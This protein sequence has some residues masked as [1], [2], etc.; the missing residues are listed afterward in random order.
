MAE[1]P[2][3]ETEKPITAPLTG[4]RSR[5]RGTR[6]V[7][8]ALAVAAAAGLLTLLAFGVTAQSPN[9]GI[10]D[11]LAAGRPAPAP[12]FS[13]A[14]IQR[15]HLGGALERRLAP[16]FTHQ[17]LGIRQLRGTPVM[18]N[19]WA[20]W[21]DPCRQEAPFLERAWRTEARPAGVLFLGL[22]QQDAT[23]DALAFIHQY[24]IDYTNVHDAG[25][26]VPQSYGA[27][28]VPETYFINAR[29]DVVDHV[30]GVISPSEMHAGLNAARTGQPL[31][32]RAGGAR[33]PSR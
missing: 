23:G 3:N 2:A 17:L 14:V 21:C 31:G 24:G 16:A 29:G 10:D 8:T 30:I 32:V 25:N 13:L 9:S 33:R 28:G 7:S 19:I 6:V 20:S 15:G 4:T 22:D 11:S 12:A 27:T 1:P 26:D 18:L 5:R